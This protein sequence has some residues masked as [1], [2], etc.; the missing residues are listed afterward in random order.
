MIVLEASQRNNIPVQGCT[1]PSHLLDLYGIQYLYHITHINNLSSILKYGVLSHNQAHQQ[2]ALTDISNQQVNARRS[3]NDPIYHR[4]LHN[5]VPLY[6]NPLNPMS[7]VRRE[8]AE[9]LVILKLDRHLL[10]KPNRLFTDG[11]AACHH[12]QFFNQLENLDQLDWRCLNSRYWNDYIDGKRTRC[13][14]VLIHKHI[15]IS[16]IQQIVTKTTTLSQCVL[17]C[18]PKDINVATQAKLFF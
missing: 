5:Y 17:H 16:A 2:C 11:N 6:F 14:E 8:F 10:L 13:S 3:T 18:V 15:P 1:N 9:Q 7:F 4:S 12:T